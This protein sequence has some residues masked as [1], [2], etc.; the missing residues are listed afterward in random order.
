MHRPPH[1]CIETE[2]VLQLEQEQRLKRRAKSPATENDA[3]PSQS[4]I[5]Q[6]PLTNATRTTPSVSSPLTRSPPLNDWY[7]SSLRDAGAFYQQGA[8]LLFQEGVVDLARA[9]GAL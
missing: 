6:R 1:P 7:A 5:H 8:H 3:C 2:V 9:R 4:H